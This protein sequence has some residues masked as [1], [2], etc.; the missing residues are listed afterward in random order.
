MLRERSIKEILLPKQ[1]LA[2]IGGSIL[3]FMMQ[4]FYYRTQFTLDRF[5]ISL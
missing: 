4:M 2:I 1:I 3:M 5:G